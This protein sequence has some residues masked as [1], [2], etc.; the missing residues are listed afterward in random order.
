MGVPGERFLDILVTNKRSGLTEDEV[1]VFALVRENC[2][3]QA[4]WPSGLCAS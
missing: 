1:V 4:I 2:L 3:D